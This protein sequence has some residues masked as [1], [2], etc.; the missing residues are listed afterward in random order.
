MNNVFGWIP[1]PFYNLTEVE[2]HPTMPEGLK[3]KIGTG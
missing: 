2:L 3:G 1:E